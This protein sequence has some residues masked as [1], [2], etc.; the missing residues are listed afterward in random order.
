[1]HDCTGKSTL[2]NEVRAVLRAVRQRVRSYVWVEG[3]A[4]LVILLGALFWIGLWLDWALEPSVAVRGV[5]FAL[6]GIALTV[7]AYRVLV[8]R[9]VRPLSDYNLALLLERH[10]PQLGDHVATAVSLA[11][12]HDR[13]DHPHPELVRQTDAA[14]AAAI[15][16]VDQG[17]LFDYRPL[18][19]RCAWASVAVISVVLF[20]TLA[21]E[22]FSFWMD[23]LALSEARWPRRVRLEVVGFDR[24]DSGRRVTT[25]ARD[26]DFELTVRADLTGEHVA[27]RRVAI[28]FR[29]PDGRR[30]RD[31]LTRVGQADPARDEF[32]LYRYTFKNVRNDLTL[33]VYGDDD[34]V[35]DLRLRV[36]DRPELV[37]IEVAC[38]YPAYLHREPQTVPATSGLR[39]PIGT[40]VTVGAAANKRLTGVVAESQNR[41]SI[42]DVS[43]TDEPSEQVEFE[44]GPLDADDTVLIHL[45]DVDGISSRGPYRL[46]LSATPDELPKVSVNLDGIG[47]AITPDARIPL[48]GRVTDD[49]GL[50]AAWFEV[51]VDKGEPQERPLTS[52][53][54]GRTRLEDLEALDLRSS[55][56]AGG[57]IDVR[58]G[59]KLSLA[60]AASDFC[61]LGDEPRVGSSQRWVLDVVTPADL[62]LLIERRELAYRQRFEAIYEKVS[63]TRSMLAR[64]DFSAPEEGGDEPSADNQNQRA[65]ALRRLRVAGAEQ[66]VTQAA[67]EVLS[68]AEGF[69]HLHDQL[70]NNRIENRELQDRLKKEI[71]DPLREISEVGMPDLRQ[72]LKS[73]EGVIADEQLGPPEVVESLAMADAVLVDM[74]HVLDRMLE[75]ETYN[76][77]VALLRGIIADQD[78]LNE[79]TKQR[80]QEGLRNLLE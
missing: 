3:L 14:S 13:P 34:R 73:V 56:A 41:E 12:E 10:D 74:Q 44:Y 6:V 35:R 9:L 38:R 72:Q 51:A 2:P 1:M 20:G 77:V 57:A 40:H 8:R 45:T 54:A 23:R 4:V 19:I 32:Q 68:V 70:V 15:K 71:A 50:R 16:N 53:L 52:T 33:D 49:Y 29:L 76:E 65:L 78:K 66:N 59:Q 26:D 17:R 42:A 47:T 11:A 69:D 64:V 80:R 28:R 61:D 58:P 5:V 21:T 55:A 24:D 37:S 31:Y 7:A 22:Q 63:D 25:I 79:Q 75:L 36:V 43:Y 39:I 62:L 67:D 48:V 60:L 18:R 30:G 46:A 27:P